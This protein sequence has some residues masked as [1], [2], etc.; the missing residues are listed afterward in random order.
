MA[1]SIIAIIPARS[2]SKGI[3]DKNIKHL[4]GHPL[5][6]FSIAAARRAEI[7]PV[8]VSTDSEDY[9]EIAI[10]YGAEV[11]FIRPAEISKDR[12][13]DFEFMRQAME[14]YKSYECTIPEYWMHLRPTTPLRDPEVLKNAVSFIAEHPKA[15]SLRSGHEA[16]ESP[17]KWFLKDENSYFKGLRDDLTP[18]KVNMPRQLFPK[19]YNPDGYVDIVRSSHV[20]N[21]ATLHGDKMLVFESPRCT[22]I[23]TPEDFKYLEYEIK[24]N[25]SPLLGW[26]DNQV[27]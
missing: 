14:W 6:A 9:A 22:E 15:T 13:T 12:S 8:I 16:P 18:E 3:L 25:S 24:Q 21:S 5:L 23:D 11:P 27:S 7:D 4:V 20:L 10:L 19:M 17:F 2:G 26:L 1:D